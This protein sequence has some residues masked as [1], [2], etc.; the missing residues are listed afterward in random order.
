[1]GELNRARVAECYGFESMLAAYRSIYRTALES[2][3]P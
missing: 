2:A 3:K 1:M